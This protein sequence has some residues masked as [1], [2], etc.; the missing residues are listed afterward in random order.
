MTELTAH[1]SKTCFYLIL[2]HKEREVL[3]E[4][5]LSEAHE[6]RSVSDF[7]VLLDAAKFVLALPVVNSY[8]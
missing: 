4:Y 7:V 1:Y 8:S 2:A 3:V 6:N 5:T